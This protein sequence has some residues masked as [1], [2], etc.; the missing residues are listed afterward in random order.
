MGV[1]E[2]RKGERIWRET[3]KIFVNTSYGN[4]IWWSER[5]WRK[6][7]ERQERETPLNS[8]LPSLT[9]SV[10][11]KPYDLISCH[12]K[13]AQILS[14]HIPEPQPH[15]LRWGSLKSQ[16]ILINYSVY[17]VPRKKKV[18]LH[19]FSIDQRYFHHLIL[20]CCKNLNTW[21]FCVIGSGNIYVSDLHKLNCPL[22]QSLYPKLSEAILWE[23]EVDIA[24]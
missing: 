17:M 5:G 19:K 15:Y 3:L 12:P 9:S 2:E 22:N 4:L 24:H 23:L 13:K 1:W 11:P 20:A 16:P 7:V 10:H 14:L 18:L 6:N 21:Q 8:V